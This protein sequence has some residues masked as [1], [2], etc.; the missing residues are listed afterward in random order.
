MNDGY[1]NDPAINEAGVFGTPATILPVEAIAELH[2]A[3]NFEAEYGRS[4]GGVVN[5]VT[6]SG[7]NARHG[8]F[9]EF[10]RNTALDARNFFNDKSVAAESFPRQSIRRFAR[11]PHHQRQDLLLHRLRRHARNRRASELPVAFP[12]PPTSPDNTPAGGINP[13]I[14]NLLAAGKAWPTP[15][16]TGSCLGNPVDGPAVSSNTVLTTP[17]SNNV[18]GG[19]I[20][21]DH[22]FNKDNLL[23]GRYFIGDS[24]QSFPLALVGGGALPNYNTFTPTRVQM[25]ALSFVSVLTPS[26]VN[27]ARLGWNRFGEGFAPQDRNFDPASIGL[28]TGG[29]GWRPFG[30]PVIDVSGLPQLGA[31]YSTTRHRVDSNWHFIDNISWKVGKHDIKLGYEYRRTTV[32]QIFDAY[33]RGR[34]NFSSFA[35]FLAGTPDGGFQY[36]GDSNRNTLRKFQRRLLPGQ[37]PRHQPGHRKLRP[38]LRLLRHRSGKARQLHQRRSRHRSSHRRWPGPSLPARLQQLGSSPQRRLGR[39][40]SSEDR[41]SRW[42]R[43]LL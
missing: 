6:K 14:A 1:R 36:S 40:G 18:N 41:R 21:I 33:F 3:S 20:K 11:R 10:F 39:H 30:M 7:T 26:I 9:F 5:V 15:N 16:G 12:P 38:A 8:S 23:T 19:M 42:L 29:T 17:F 43:H 37:L 4:A 2:V 25:V 24:D 27:E 22:N 35:D 34:L 28:N 32:S 31:S 13:V